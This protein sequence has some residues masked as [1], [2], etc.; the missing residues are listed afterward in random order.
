MQPILLFLDM[1]VSVAT[2][3]KVSLKLLQASKTLEQVPTNSSLA[4]GHHFLSL[5]SI[6]LP[7]GSDEKLV[8]EQGYHFPRWSTLIS[9][10]V[11]L[12]IEGWNSVEWPDFL[13]QS[14]SFS[15][16]PCMVANAEKLF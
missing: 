5:V 9:S 6:T 8:W 7:T 10:T 2:N 14:R 16:L 13:Q 3:C 4:S 1:D 12:S 15:M 11:K